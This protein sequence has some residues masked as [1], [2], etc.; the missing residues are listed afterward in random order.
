M[1]LNKTIIS[2]SIISLFILFE[3]N[4]FLILMGMELIIVCNLP[5]FISVIVMKILWL[6]LILLTLHMLIT[7]IMN[8]QCHKKLLIKLFVS[9]IVLY[10]LNFFSA[11]IGYI[12]F[13]NTNDYIHKQKTF[14]DNSPDSFVL[15]LLNLIH[16]AI[17]IVVV[18]WLGL[19]EK[20]E[21]LT[22]EKNEHQKE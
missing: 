20:V 4:V 19:K 5:A 9:Y 6:I 18:F 16:N 2:C 3:L 14:M 22:S 17:L 1:T 8:S 13:K 7:R 12:I 11:D 21:N 10:L 15:M